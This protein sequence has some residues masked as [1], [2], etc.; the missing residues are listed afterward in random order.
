MGQP[1]SV[2]SVQSVVKKIHMTRAIEGY[3]E[4][5]EFYELFSNRCNCLHGA[6]P[7]GKNQT[8]VYWEQ[9]DSQKPF[10][11]DNGLNGLHGLL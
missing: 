3:Y 5:C 1:K 9:R 4:L 11:E 7:C 2:Q 8:A 6:N 10:C